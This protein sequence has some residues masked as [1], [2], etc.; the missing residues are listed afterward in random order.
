VTWLSQSR[1]AQ[2]YRRL[3]PFRF[4]TTIAA[5]VGWMIAGIWIRISLD[6]PDGY[7]FHCHGKG[8]LITDLTHSTALF[9]RGHGSIMEIAE[10]LWI[11]SIPVFGVTYV[12][13][14]FFKSRPIANFTSSTE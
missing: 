8:C 5:F 4:F 3:G 6:W 10:F 13:L 7:G 9:G 11:W 1:A 12:I 14:P 2:T